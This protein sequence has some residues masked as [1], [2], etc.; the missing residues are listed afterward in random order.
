MPL[1][2]RIREFIRIFETSTR[3]LHVC[4]ISEEEVVLK[5]KENREGPGALSRDLILTRLAQAFGLSTFSL[6]VLKIESGDADL[7]NVTLQ[8][9]GVQHD[10]LTAGH[11]LCSR[12][13]E[14]SPWDGKEAWIRQISNKKDI[15]RLVLFDTWIRNGDRCAPRR[16]NRK[17]NYGNVWLSAQEG[18]QVM[19]KAIDH[20]HCLCSGSLRNLRKIHEVRDKGLFSYFK[21]WRPYI[22][23]ALIEEGLRALDVLIK[24]SRCIDEA[25]QE[26]PDDWQLS[27][28]DRN[29]IRTFLSDR[30]RWIV[31]NFPQALNADALNVDE[32]DEVIL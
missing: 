30:G 21:N 18:A 23:R 4:L 19:L 29:D 10:A 7:L 26:V 2:V 12:Y 8:D 17:P 5:V 14:G 32:N 28:Q 1:D 27:S 22:S 6:N 3:P 16:D 11:A 31:E 24:D 15:A 20:T 13:E 9:R 25:I